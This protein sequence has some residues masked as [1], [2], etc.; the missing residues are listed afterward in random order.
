MSTELLKSVSL[1]KKADFN[2][3]KGA[4]IVSKNV[5]LS[6]EEIENG[7]LLKKSYDIKWIKEG[8]DD[9]SYEYFSRTWF[10][11]EN[12]IQITLPNDTKSLADKLD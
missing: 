3:P 2:L 6:A 8:S 12:P 10:S 9:T 5:T 1:E 4:T 7:F 11:K